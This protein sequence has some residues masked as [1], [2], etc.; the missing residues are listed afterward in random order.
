MF[1]SNLVMPGRD[2]NLGS[3]TDWLA[4]LPCGLWI[5]GRDLLKPRNTSRMFGCF[6]LLHPWKLMTSP[7][8]GPF[9]E[10][11]LVFN[12]HFSG[13][14]V[15]FR[16]WKNASPPPFLTGFPGSMEG[17]GPFPTNLTAANKESSPLFRIGMDGFDWWN[18][19]FGVSFTGK[20]KPVRIKG[21]L[22]V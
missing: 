13:D 14:H 4:F 8:K 17:Q 12:H 9:L 7:N 11:R 1:P 20:L 15:S 3:H 22:W 18:G 5:G 6:F 16:V 19:T 21:P 2:Q 10:E